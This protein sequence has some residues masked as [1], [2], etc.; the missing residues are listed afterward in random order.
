MTDGFP[1]LGPDEV[2]VWEIDLDAALDDSVLSRDER[3]R[4]AG[5][6]FEIHRKRFA[7][8]RAA[9]RRLLGA[10]LQKPA[11]AISFVYGSAGKP[12]IQGAHFAFNLAHTEGIGILGV[13]RRPR[14]GADVEILRGMDDMPDVAKYAFAPSEVARW[15]ALPESEKTRAFHRCWTRKE[16]YLKAT[17]EGI[18]ERLHS[19]EVAFEPNAAPQI[20]SGADGEWTLIDISR[21]PNYAAAIA[22]QGS[23][24][25]IRRFDSQDWLRKFD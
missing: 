12:E 21:E 4:L 7:T 8:G 17:G 20:L 18:A 22:V 13:T 15:E 11:A 10:Y 23:N 3:T 14:I 5:Y 16:A 6:K 24:V 25:T 19:F 1:E 2:H 9:L